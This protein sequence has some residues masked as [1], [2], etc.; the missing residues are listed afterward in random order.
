MMIHLKD[1]PSPRSRTPH[2]TLSRISE[3]NLSSSLLSPLSSLLSPLLSDSPKLICVTRLMYGESGSQPR[4]PDSYDL[5]E[6]GSVDLDREVFDLSGK[7]SPM[8]RPIIV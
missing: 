1:D 6:D 5:L 7:P 8:R 2:L 3:G 4:S